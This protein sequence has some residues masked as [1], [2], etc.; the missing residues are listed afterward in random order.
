MYINYLY[1]LV[2]ITKEASTDGALHPPRQCVTSNRWLGI[3]PGQVLSDVVG[4]TINI[5]KCEIFS[6]S[7]IS[8]FPP[9]MKGSNCPNLVILGIP[10]GDQ[11]FCSAFISGK[12]GEAKALLL[13]PEEVISVQVSARRLTLPKVLHPPKLCQHLRPLIS[14]STVVSHVALQLT[15]QISPDSRQSLV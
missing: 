14:I 2:P 11:A 15:H 1:L 7:D 5:P 12:H 8:S 4:L 10:I 3:V 6:H 13:Q 9:A